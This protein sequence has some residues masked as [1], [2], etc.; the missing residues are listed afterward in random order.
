MRSAQQLL[1]HHAEQQQQRRQHHEALV[2]PFWAQSLLPSTLPMALPMAFPTV[3]PAL[4]PAVLPTVLPTPIVPVSE[5]LDTVAAP[6]QGRDALRTSKVEGP[7]LGSVQAPAV[8]ASLRQPPNTPPLVDLSWLNNAFES[9]LAAPS[10]D[11][12]MASAIAAWRRHA[13]RM[14]QASMC[15]DRVR[16]HCKQA[17][18]RRALRRFATF[19]H[20]LWRARKLNVE[21]VRRGRVALRQRSFTHWRMLART[22]ARAAVARHIQERRRL[23]HAMHVWRCQPKRRRFVSLTTV[24]TEIA[25]LLRP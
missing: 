18:C 11:A 16:A 10:D 24:R 20:Q 19:V 12:R 17:A 1:L 2:Q 8:V 15:S 5:A 22:W 7:S 23:R 9:A 6:E 4:Q 13:M 25:S 21:C 3:L 14:W